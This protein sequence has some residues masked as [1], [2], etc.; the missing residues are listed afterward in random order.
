MVRFSMRTKISIDDIIIQIKEGESL[1]IDIETDLK[2][3]R[4]LVM[5]AHAWDEKYELL[6][7][8]SYML[9]EEHLLEVKNQMLVTPSMLQCYSQFKFWL[10]LE[11]VCGELTKIDSPHFS[12]T[13]ET[14]E[15]VI[16]LMNELAGKSL[17]ENLKQKKDNMLNFQQLYKYWDYIKQYREKARVVLSGP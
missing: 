15:E 14:I 4:D 7:E 12:R 13:L 1:R 17:E 11:S 9:V 10:I 8:K 2:P 6:E 16:K 3:I 5:E